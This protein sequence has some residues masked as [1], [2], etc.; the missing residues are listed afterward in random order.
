MVPCHTFIT[1]YYE[2]KIV[3][4]QGNCWK[5]PPVE[6]GCGGRGSEGREGSM[7]EGDLSKFFRLDD[8]IVM[9]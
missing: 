4:E 2:W 8:R 1:F 9:R 6:R 5:T 3:H 7:E